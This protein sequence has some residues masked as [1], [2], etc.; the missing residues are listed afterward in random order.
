MSG[1]IKNKS[2]HL[3]QI[4][5]VEDHLHI[6]T[7]LHPSVSLAS[8]IKDIKISSNGF[9]KERRLFPEFIGWQD[10]YN[11]FTYAYNAVPDLIKYIQNQEEHHKKV[12]Y[13][14]EVKAFF[15]EHGIVFEEKYI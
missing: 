9:I 11:A 10:G 14:E 5:G 4:N 13:L 1:L 12:T 15:K 6:L 3:Y 8:F 2:C 7:H